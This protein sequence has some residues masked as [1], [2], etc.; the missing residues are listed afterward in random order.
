MGVI[1]TVTGQDVV[2]DEHDEDRGEKEVRRRQ[3]RREP[4]GACPLHLTDICGAIRKIID[5]DEQT[6]KTRQI[7]WEDDGQGGLVA[8]VPLDDG[9]QFVLRC[10][11]FDSVLAWMPR[12]YLDRGRGEEGGEFPLVVPPYASDSRIGPTVR[13]PTIE[14]AMRGWAWG[15]PKSIPMAEDMSRADHEILRT[16]LGARPGESTLD[17]GRRVVTEE[18]AVIVAAMDST[19]DLATRL[20]QATATAEKAQAEADRLCAERGFLAEAIAAAALKAGGYNGEAPL[21]G[22]HLVMLCQDMAAEIERQTAIAN[23][24]LRALKQDTTEEDRA[25]A[26]A[27][28]EA[29][30][31]LPPGTGELASTRSV[32]AASGW[33]MALALAVQYGQRGA[34]RTARE[35]LAAL[36]VDPCKTANTANAPATRRPGNER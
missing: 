34:E 26:I 3:E 27:S 4:A 2:G 13:E 31:A 1:G 17:A 15:E 8:H 18:S 23:A 10:D 36:G 24:A 7:A 6:M 30:D 19:A 28:L 22:P 20:A 21:T 5:G 33:R 29:I 14:A 9:R 11:Y 35:A 25:L 16:V 32:S 12:L